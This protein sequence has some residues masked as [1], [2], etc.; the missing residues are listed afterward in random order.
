[1]AKTLNECDAMYYYE[2]VGKKTHWKYR[3]MFIPSYDADLGSAYN[4]YKLPD[5]LITNMS[6]EW[7]FEDEK[8]IGTPQMPSLTFDIDLAQLGGQ[9]LHPEFNIF[10]KLLVEDTALINYSQTLDRFSFDVKFYS[11]NVWYLIVDYSGVGDTWRCLFAGVQEHKTENTINKSENKMTIEAIDIGKIICEKVKGTWVTYFHGHNLTYGSNQQI[12]FATYVIDSLV[13]STD[14]KGVFNTFRHI[15]ESLYFMGMANMVD[16]HNFIEDDL[17]EPILRKYLRNPT[18]I[19]FFEIDYGQH[20]KQKYDGSGD[21][22]SSTVSGNVWFIAYNKV[23]K[24][25]RNVPRQYIYGGSLIKIF[26]DETNTL[27]DYL[28]D[29]MAQTCQNLWTTFA[30]ASPTGIGLIT[31]ENNLLFTSLKTQ[32]YE[33]DITDFIISIDAQKVTEVEISIFD[34]VGKDND[35]IVFPSKLPVPFLGNQI[36]NFA[37]YEVIGTRTDNKVQVV[38]YFHNLPVIPDNYRESSGF[39]AKVKVG[40]LAY[41]SHDLALVYK[42]TPLKADTSTFINDPYN[43]IRNHEKCKFLLGAGINSD[44]V[45]ITAEHEFILSQVRNSPVY[46]Y[47]FGDI[48]HPLHEKELNGLWNFNGQAMILA[49]LYYYLFNHTGQNKISG[50][51]D[52]NKGYNTD[53]ALSEYNIWFR[54]DVACFDL[55]LAGNPAPYD[56][57]FGTL[58]TKYKLTKCKVNL[59]TD[60]LADSE[61]VEFEALST[62]A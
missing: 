40:L 18:S 31:I 58:N 6:Y 42:D 10:A 15:D 30:S 12:Q 45:I 39:D 22:G 53:V 36:I 47:G 59:I 48:N 62:Y 52:M 29:M 43:F 54:C 44:D 32:I 27:W 1:M 7:E 17:L 3:L 35:K 38:L 41:D 5:T 24:I 49:Q 51:I 23:D 14:N 55:T 57:M 4:L 60:S 13:E 28:S 16:F 25:L 21:R 56:T 19:L 50:K 8:Y 34:K 61:I 9:A 33:K 46:S 2:W 20:Y 11:G 26:G 37:D